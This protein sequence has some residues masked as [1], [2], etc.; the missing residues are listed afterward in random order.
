MSTSDN[1]SDDTEWSIHKRNK[2][3]SISI[4]DDVQKIIVPINNKDDKLAK[5]I[6][7]SCIVYRLYGGKTL[8]F[9]TV[10]YCAF[11]IKMWKIL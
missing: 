8:I 9:S 4:K 2:N 7:V 1:D 5:Q 6:D 10:F 3:C 11:I